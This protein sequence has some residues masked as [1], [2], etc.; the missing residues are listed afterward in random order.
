MEAGVGGW[1]WG[2]GNPHL[3]VLSLSPAV[4]IPEVPAIFQPG[5]H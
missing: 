1:G 4:L 2:L 3:T 5:L